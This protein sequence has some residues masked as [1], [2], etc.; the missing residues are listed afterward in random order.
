MTAAVVSLLAIG[1]LSGCVQFGDYVGESDLRCAERAVSFETYLGDKEGIDTASV[2]PAGKGTAGQCVIE[3]VV[4]V[5]SSSSPQDLVAVSATALDSVEF[6]GYTPS[7]TK[8]D[9]QIED[10]ELLNVLPPSMATKDDR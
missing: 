3:V 4:G 5:S 1:S 7:E 9:I 6:A 8:L 2:R 10:G